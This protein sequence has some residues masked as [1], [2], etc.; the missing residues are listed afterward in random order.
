[1]LQKAVIF[2]CS[3]YLTLPGK[4][5]YAYPRNINLYDSSEQTTKLNWIPSNT[6][7]RGYY[8]EPPS[9]ASFS[10]P[11]QKPNESL[12]IIESQASVFFQRNHWSTFSGH[13][14]VSQPGRIIKAEQVRIYQNPETGQPQLLE[15]NGDVNFHEPGKHLVSERAS[16]NLETKTGELDNSFYRIYTKTPTGYQNATG[17]ATQILRPNQEVLVL[18]NGTYSTCSPLN[19]VWEIKTSKLVLDEKT[20]WG[21]ARKIRMYFKKKKIFSFPYFTFP[22][23]KKRKSGFLYPTSGYSD[24]QLG[25]FVGIPYYFNLA[26]NYDETLTFTPNTKRVLLL[27]SKFRYLTRK[28]QGTFLV[29]LLPYDPAF[30][31]FINT[32]TINDF[33]GPDREYIRASLNRLKNS[34]PTRS[35]LHFYNTSQI[36]PNWKSDL[37]LN[38][39]SDDYYFQ[40]TT[41]RY[42]PQNTDQLLN[43]F[44]L[45]YTDAHWDFSG[46]LQSYQT[47]H[48]ANQP[49]INN[50]Y[51]RLP[52]LNLGGNWFDPKTSLEYQLQA[53]FVHFEIDEFGKNFFY[54]YYYY[55]NQNLFVLPEGNRAHL[56]P[57][58][59]WQK[60]FPFG[61]FRPTAQFDVTSYNLDRSQ[62]ICCF[63][64]RIDRSLPIFNID[65]GLYFER[66]ISFLRTL[67]LQTLEPRFF[68]LYVPYRKQKDIPDFDTVLPPFSFS[69]LFRTN[70]FIGIDRISNANQLSVGL[71]SRFLDT[72]NGVEKLQL[73]LGQIFYFQPPRVSLNA[74]QYF[75]PGV[76]PTTPE[77][78]YSSL[79][80]KYSP[81]VQELT[82]HLNPK[83]DAIVNTTWNFARRQHYKK[84][85][86]WKIKNYPQSYWDYNHY[87]HFHHSMENASLQLSYRPKENA[88]FNMAYEFIQN[89]N[90]DNV[91][92]GNVNRLKLSMSYPINQRWNILGGWYY[93]IRPNYTQNL[94]AG[95][96]YNDCCWAVRL[97]ATQELIAQGQSDRDPQRN[98]TNG[99]YL[100]FQLK[101][102]GNFGQNVD[103]ML[104]NNIPGY[105]NQ[106]FGE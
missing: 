67:Y 17:E 37:H 41:N 18:Q 21:S 33:R 66:Q 1:M 86:D 64:R 46:I 30:K 13:T 93:N 79:N 90:Y 49:L 14:V 40:D 65:T 72:L 38:Y 101:G 11:L 82:Y 31:H 60:L 104:T 50:I 74:Q 57:S 5:S 3:L 94:L 4:A 25:A 103:P 98:Y 29:D 61:F 34:H 23:T 87:R 100:Q 26:P 39:V 15:L 84:F 8:K 16:F 52:Q 70:R 9:I 7:C 22:L 51:K 88:V 59:S 6:L 28:S 20:E 2:F 97:I 48:P 43:R 58:I 83:W 12:T 76:P 80:Q 35:Y 56:L 55:P 42:S 63:R 91:D 95:I 78:D 36:N 75:Y 85:L 27:E 47:L 99:F 106:I 73:N 53:D 68:Y 19:K 62:P 105:R 96:E 71:T 44:S 77:F 45:E 54:P 24:K 32:S 69:Q 102:L 81:F 89:I 92:R 10:S